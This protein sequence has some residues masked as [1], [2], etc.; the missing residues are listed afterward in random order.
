MHSVSRIR[1]AKFLVLCNLARQYGIIAPQEVHGDEVVL[2]MRAHGLLRSHVF[3]P[4]FCKNRQGDTIV[5]TGGVG[6]LV[7]RRFCIKLSDG[8]LV[9]VGDFGP[10]L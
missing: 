9:P 2:A 6:F 1:E 8:S 10:C 4:S 3:F 5:D 7:D